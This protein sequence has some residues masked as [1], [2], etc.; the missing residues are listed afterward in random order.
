MKGQGGDVISCHGLPLNGRSSGKR[1]A[2]ASQN[3]REFGVYEGR[4]RAATS[5]RNLSEYCRNMGKVPGSMAEIWQKYMLQHKD[6]IPPHTSSEPLDISGPLADGCSVI[7][8]VGCCSL[9]G[10]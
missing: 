7:K 2:V 4:G 1:G 3:P 10:A 8:G 6:C 9:E 5:C